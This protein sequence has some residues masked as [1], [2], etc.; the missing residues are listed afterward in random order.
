[1]AIHQMATPKKKIVGQLVCGPGE[2]GRY[3]K[4]TLD[5]FK[6]LCDDVVV[7]LCNATQAEKD[8]VRSYNFRSYEDNREWG[9][10]QPDIKTRLL[11]TILL[12][13]PDWILVLDADETMPGMDRDTLEGLTRN[14]E[15]CFFYIVNLWDDEQ[16]YTKTMSFWNVRFYKADP[17]KGVQFL[18]KPVHCGNA[19]PYFY[20]IAAKQSYVPHIV[21]HKGLMK[22]E[23]RVK[24]SDR[25]KVYDPRA[26]HKG[27]DYYDALL[28]KKQPALYNQDEITNKLKNYYESIKH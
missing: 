18:R 25:Y 9:I 21:L 3:L 28:Y 17:S 14:R 15:S 1:M 23:D 10:S 6:R 16:H 12:L 2:A 20:T 5:D 8:M 22:P 7:C 13:N 24:K 19:P 27:R 26:I 11:K 4:E